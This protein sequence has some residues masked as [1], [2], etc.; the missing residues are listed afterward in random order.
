MRGGF[1]NRSID[2]RDKDRWKL[3]FQV[4]CIMD[5][6]ALSMQVEHIRAAQEGLFLQGYVSGC[7]AYGYGGEVVD[8][9]VA[10]GGRPRRKIVIDPETAEWVRKTFDG[11]VDERLSMT[12]LAKRLNGQNAPLS[13]CSNGKNWTAKAVRYLLTNPCY[14]GEFSYG[15]TRRVWL[16]SKDYSKSVRREEPL[17]VQHFEHLRIVSDERWNRAQELIAGLTRAQSGR[18]PKQVREGD[19]PRALNGLLFCPTHKRPLKT[20][21]SYAKRVDCLED[22]F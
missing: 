16:S 3:M 6:Q 20:T 10:K 15:K 18:P 2:T 9:Q 12:E 21:G 13:P 14:R 22:Q 4:H 8:G 17:K 5:E 7:L 1:T 19:R 11:F